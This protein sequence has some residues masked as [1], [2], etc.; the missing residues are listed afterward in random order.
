VAEQLLEEYGAY[1]T[2]VAEYADLFEAATRVIADENE[3]DVLGE[4]RR[5]HAQH[6][7]EQLPD[8]LGLLG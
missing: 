3:R 2:S 1:T 6:W 5:R 7:R 4:E 8:G